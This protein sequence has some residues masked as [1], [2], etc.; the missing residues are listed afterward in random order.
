MPAHI[1]H[2]DC[3]FIIIP[4]LHMSYYLFKQILSYNNIPIC[5]QYTN[6]DYHIVI[7]KVE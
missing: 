1:Q 3:C 6:I 4:V 5:V 7:K 2:S